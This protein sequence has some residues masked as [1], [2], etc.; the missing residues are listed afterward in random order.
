MDL[1][2]SLYDLMHEGFG[3]RPVRAVEKLE[4]VEARHSD[5]RSLGVRRDAPLLLVERIGYA[6]DGTPVEF[7]R[8]R[9]RADRTRLEIES[10]S[11]SE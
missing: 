10:A 8:D 3:L 6:V 9:F 1:S 5:A 4:I 7:A 11:I 2:G